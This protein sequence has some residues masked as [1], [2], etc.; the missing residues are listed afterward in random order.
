MLTRLLS[1]KRQRERDAIARL[2][3]AQH[4]YNRLHAAC[5]AKEQQLMDYADWRKQEEARLYEAVHRQKLSPTKLES[6]RRQI[7]FLR[8]RELKLEDELAD[9]R[10]AFEVAG[11][12]L[13]E[14]RRRGLDARREVIRFEEYVSRLAETEKLHAERGEETETEETVATRFTV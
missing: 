11:Q 7:G 9:A 2:G 8:S 1:I 10:H 13:E 6:Y 3:E 14:S 12:N 5:Q 4:E